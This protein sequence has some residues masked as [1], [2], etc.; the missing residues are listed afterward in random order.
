MSSVSRLSALT[1]R[2]NSQILLMAPNNVDLAKSRE[3]KDFLSSSPDAKA[4]IPM[5]YRGSAASHQNS[6]RYMVNPVTGHT[7]EL[8]YSTLSRIQGVSQGRRLP[9]KTRH[10]IDLTAAN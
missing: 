1:R 9:D 5:K 10:T 2:R 7:K 3:I 8:D 6:V 4:P